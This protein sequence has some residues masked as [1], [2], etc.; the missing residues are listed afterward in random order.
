MK[1]FFL[2]LSL[3]PVLAQANCFTL[4]VSKWT[5]KQMERV[6]EVCTKTVG[7][8]CSSR[9]ADPKLPSYLLCAG[10]A[11]L[12]KL[13]SVSLLSQAEAAR[14]IAADT[15]M[16]Q[17]QAAEALLA[18]AKDSPLCNVEVTE[19]PTVMKGLSNDQ[20]LEE[21]LKCFIALRKGALQ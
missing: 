7:E 14:I 11:D 20:A 19:V 3:I 16:A 9:V 10:K 1:G 18:V 17:V 15:Q 4:D 5:L 12:T 8:T 21:L 13:D 6:E 2:L